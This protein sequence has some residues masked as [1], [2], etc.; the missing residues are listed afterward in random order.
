MANFKIYKESDNAGVEYLEKASA[1]VIE[2]GSLVALD[3]SGLAITADETSTAVAF[4]EGGAGDGETK[5]GVIT[6]ER[7][8]LEWTAESAFADSSRWT[9][10]GIDATQNIDF[11]TPANDTLKVLPGLDAGTD[12][13]TDQVRVRI[14]ST[15]Y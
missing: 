2:A 8:V 14:E 15:L 13:S 12:G 4:T 5:V 9:L 1:T 6:D 7:L 11:T 10:T 3:A